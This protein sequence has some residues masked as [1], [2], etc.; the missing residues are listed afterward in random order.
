MHP[1]KNEYKQTVIY[2][3]DS[4][5]SESNGIGVDDL[6]NKYRKN[7]SGS[8]KTNGVTK[9][10]RAVLHDNFCSLVIRGSA[11]I[12]FVINYLLMNCHRGILAITTLP[13]EYTLHH[14]QDAYVLLGHEKAV[15]LPERSNIRVPQI[16]RSSMLIIKYVQCQQS[17]YLWYIKVKVTT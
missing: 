5:H 1:N 3:T 15:T 14:F 2:F 12:N 8:L 9:S 16:A 4:Y 7:M 10:R 13:N 11:A 17:H 6:Y